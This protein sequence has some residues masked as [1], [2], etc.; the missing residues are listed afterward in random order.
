M[1][2]VNTH[3]G[4]FSHTQCPKRFCNNVKF[5]FGFRQIVFIGV[6]IF[7]LYIVRFNKFR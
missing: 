1:R 5:N 6:F 7:I 3:R 4:K 2:A